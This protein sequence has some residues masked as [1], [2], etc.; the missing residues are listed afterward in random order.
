MLTPFDDYPIHASADPIATPASADPNHYDRYWFN[1]HQRDGDFY[2]GASMGHY[3]VRG[4]IDAAFSIVKDG[5]EHS[6]FA[7]GAMPQDR[8]TAIGPIRIE[9]IEPMRVIRFVV[10]PNDHGITCD[11]TFRATT[12]A[13]EE[14]RQQR[15]TVEGVLLTDHTR[16]TQWG[17]W[18]GAIAVD[19]DEVAVHPTQVSGTRDRSWGIRPVGDQVP[20]LREPMPFQ[21]FWLWA[22]LHFGDR[23]THFAFHEH[24][25]G[26]RWLETAQVLAPLA[27][28]TAPWSRTGV[29]ECHDIAYDIEW[30]PGRRELRRARLSF[31]DPV[32]GATHIEIE[33]VFTF[34]MRGIGYWHPY[35][36][37]GS[38]HGVL[39]TGRE[40]IALDDFDPTDFA[41][42][43]LQ[44]LVL[45]TM[46]DRRGVGVVE[47]IAIGPHQPSGLTGFTDGWSAS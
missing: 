9:V 23:F 40:S 21:V 31:Q 19:G 25:D 29:R 26:R 13:I 33:K 30:E 18:E 45:A 7:S 44:N 41:S 22:P 34:R 12:V 5:I 11:L 20:V 36:S 6:V 27:A 14:P 32:E 4:G 47:Q 28:D 24:E 1:G 16:L 42:I 17:T 3:P 46:G 10:E 39:E 37:H 43:H 2:F 35:W 8:S 38:N 15:R